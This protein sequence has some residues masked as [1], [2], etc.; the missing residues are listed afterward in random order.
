MQ[1]VSGPYRFLRRRLVAYI[2]S[3]A[4]GNQELKLQVTEDQK[5]KTTRAVVKASNF[6][7][8]A[9]QARPRNST[10]TTTTSNPARQQHRLVPQ[11]RGAIQE[12]Y[13]PCFRSRKPGFQFS[14]KQSRCWQNS[15]WLLPSMN[16]LPQKE[17]LESSTNKINFTSER[18]SICTGKASLNR[19]PMAGDYTL[20]PMAGTK[21]HA[22]HNE[23]ESTNW[24]AGSPNYLP[25][26]RQSP[27]ARYD[28]AQN[29]PSVTYGKGAT[30]G[31]T[32]RG[33]AK[34]QPCSTSKVQPFYRRLQR[35]LPR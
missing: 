17:Y 29:K 22:K 26:W 13:G 18:N 6:L 25:N 33:S 1:W 11:P 8:P 21:T 34:S 14:S 9:D 15:Q 35:N 27:Q 7:N 20:K 19:Q 12:E 32:W 10:P 16:R 23:K 2:P 3:R 24:W 28:N 5:T 30:D 31:N 4:Q